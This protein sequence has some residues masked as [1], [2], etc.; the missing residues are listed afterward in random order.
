VSA[1]LL[2]LQQVVRRF[3]TAAGS[4]TVLDGLT[5]TLEHGGAA[6]IQGASGCGKSTLLNLI[7]ALDRPTSGRV[8]LDGE[9]LTELDDDARSRLRARKIGF[10]FQEHHLLPQ[11]SAIENVLVPTLALGPAA[12]PESVARADSL[13]ARVGLADHA[14]KR[15]H[16][17]SGGQRQRV[18]VVRALINEP[19]LLLADEPTG[20]LDRAAAETL[21]ELL[22]ELNR[23]ARLALVV[24]THSAHVAL[25]VGSV[26]DLLDGKLRSAGP[27]ACATGD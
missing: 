8:L 22:V 11:C 2:D 16:Q 15:P 20:S 4:Q 1:P 21:V 23:E 5:W 25:R 27:G 19:I 3:D 24:A 9:S 14:H 7:G 26:F 18:A 12:R 17:L 13:L 6:A 10:V